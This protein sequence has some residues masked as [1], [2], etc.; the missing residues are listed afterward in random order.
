MTDLQSLARIEQAEQILW[1]AIADVPLTCSAQE[2]AAAVQGLGLRM[3]EGCLTPRAIAHNLI[4]QAEAYLKAAGESFDAS[5][6]GTTAETL[7]MTEAAHHILTGAAKAMMAHGIPSADA[8]Q[9]M[10][11]YAAAWA[12]KDD[13]DAAM[14]LYR[15]A[16]AI[17]SKGQSKH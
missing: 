4:N 3:A 7:T 11:G 1:Q 10:L 13:P 14:N 16:D 9:L 12:G 15:Y 5:P 6:S 8:R 2:T 17:I